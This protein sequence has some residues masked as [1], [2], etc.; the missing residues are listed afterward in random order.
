MNAFAQ[1]TGGD[2]MT[3]SVYRFVEHTIRHA[4]E[5]GAIFELFCATC[6]E[7]S[8]PQV[9]Q[10]TAQDWALKHTAR[11]ATHDLF[12]REVTDYARVTREGS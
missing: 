5:G 10:D 11:N 8:G 7:T 3:R 2:S 6:P 12:R 9:Q 4:P 1:K